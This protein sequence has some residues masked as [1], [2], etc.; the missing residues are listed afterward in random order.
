M[1]RKMLCLASLMLAALAILPGDVVGQAKKKNI[2]QAMPA[3]DQ[4][5]IF[6]ELAKSV[7]GQILSFDDSAKTVSVRVD[8]TDW[9]PNPAYKPI[10]NQYGQLMQH[11][12]QLAQQQTQLAAAKTAAQK[13]THMRQIAKLQGLINQEMGKL[14]AVNSNNLPLKAQKHTRDFDLVM[15]DKIVYRKMT[16]E[17]EYDDTGNVKTRTTEEIA[18]LKGNDPKQLGYKAMPSEFH[19]NQIVF[20][21]VSPA[22]KESKSSSSSTGTTDDKDD[23]ADAAKKDMVAV[24]KPTVR[25]LIIDKE[26]AAIA[27]PTTPKK[28]N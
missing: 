12:N 1:H 15:Q 8:G 3:T 27:T 20:I 5:Y 16:L 17:L 23:K 22:K 14:S 24:D 21:Y 13:Q 11:Q 26:G 7:S 9:V 18:K 10:G 4:D 25:M 6:L 19:A 2:N 28:K